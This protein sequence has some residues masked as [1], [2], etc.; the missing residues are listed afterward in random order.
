MHNITLE[1][2]RDGLLN[3]QTGEQYVAAEYTVGR[4]GN[5]TS[6]GSQQRKDNATVEATLEAA[7]RGAF[8][9]DAASLSFQGLYDA[10]RM[11]KLLHRTDGK[12]LSPEF[13]RPLD[14]EYKAARGS[15]SAYAYEVLPL[16]HTLLSN[17]HLEPEQF[18]ND[19]LAFL[20]GFRGH[21]SPLMREFAS[22]AGRGLKGADAAGPSDHA[23]SL[24]KVPLVVAR[25][26]GDA[27][28]ADRLA[29]VIAV[30][31]TNE[32]AT[33]AGIVFSAI[34]ERMGLLGATLQEAAEWVAGEGSLL[35]S[36]RRWVREVL[37]QRDMGSVE[38]VQHFGRGPKAVSVLQSSLH[39]A[40]TAGSYV[41]GVRNN[42]LAGGDTTSRAHVV[43]ALLAAQHGDSSLPK[44][45]MKKATKFMD[46]K[47]MVHVII[48]QRTQFVP[49]FIN[50][51]PRQQPDAP[52]NVTFV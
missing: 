41:E 45:W 38:G 1:T 14:I 20:R 32:D 51:D 21:S 17:N 18:R 16:M 33:L 4:V 47:Q 50:R 8:L 29:A 34:L 48:V 43:G 52:R 37:Q 26:A 9:A 28:L 39:L 46:V 15:F 7:V 12:S 49:F 31:Q 35:E 24:V 2:G 19:S 27:E 22:K 40:L 44:R 10:D 30:H 5:W 3:T 13:H 11:H 25:Y 6:A 23:H 36:G 42:I